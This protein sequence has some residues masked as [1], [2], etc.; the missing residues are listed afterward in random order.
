MLPMQPLRDFSLSRVYAGHNFFPLADQFL[1]VPRKFAARLFGTVQ[2]CYDCELLRKQTDSSIPAQ[3]ETLLRL[4]LHRAGIPLGYFEFPVV[5]VRGR[6]GGVCGVLH[7]HKLT[8]RM[9]GTSGLLKMETETRREQIGKGQKVEGEEGEGREGGQARSGF[10]CMEAMNHWHRRA[11]QEMFP[12]LSDHRSGRFR[13]HPASDD[14]ERVRQGETDDFSETEGH[15]RCTECSPDGPDGDCGF[16]VGDECVSSLSKNSGISDQTERVRECREDSDNEMEVTGS[17]DH[18]AHDVADGSSGSG[19]EDAMTGRSSNSGM[20]DA[21]AMSFA[22]ASRRITGL[23]HE[24]RDLLRAIRIH[25]MPEEISRSYLLAHHYPFHQVDGGRLDEIA[26]L[27]GFHVSEATFNRMALA[28]ACLLLDTT[29]DGGGTMDEGDKAE[30][31]EGEEEAAP[32]PLPHHRPG[33]YHHDPLVSEAIAGGAG[34]STRRRG[35]GSIGFSPVEG[36]RG[37]DG[38]ERAPPLQHREREALTLKVIGSGYDGDLQASVNC[39][40]VHPLHD[41]WMTLLDQGFQP[42][43]TICRGPTGPCLSRALAELPIEL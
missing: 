26:I 43:E 18:R 13:L 12:P 20:T 1:L 8:C 15:T 23:H 27:E 31:K 17:G 34:G 19:H 29:Q 39:S 35:G 4:A 25:A 38:G 33:R 11:C 24:L 40:L 37:E 36:A 14:W 10:S 7:P 6:E 5:I 21:G 32:S 42:S 30:F 9:L 28:F 16:L 41:V 22:D 3:T 2:L